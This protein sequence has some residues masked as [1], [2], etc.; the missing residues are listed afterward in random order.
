MKQL[1][2]RNTP[3]GVIWQ[4]Y[5][6]KEDYERIILERNARANG[7]QSF[8]VFDII[9]YD[10][11]REETF[12]DWREHEGWKKCVEDYNSGMSA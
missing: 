4:V 12:P 7:F 10:Y 3:D 5:N 6:L 11:E 1:L 2:I 8:E 9:R